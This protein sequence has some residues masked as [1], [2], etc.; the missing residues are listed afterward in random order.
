[1][2]SDT[3]VSAFAAYQAANVNSNNSAARKKRASGR[4]DS[5]ELDTNLADQLRKY[6]KK[7][8]KASRSKSKERSKKQQ[9]VR[10]NGHSENGDKHAKISVSIHLLNDEKSEILN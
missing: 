5:F 6:V 7:S 8:K 4:R 10:T 2:P 1:M 3:N 9:D